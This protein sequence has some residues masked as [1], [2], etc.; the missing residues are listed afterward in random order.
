MKNQH[1][2]FTNTCPEGKPILTPRQFE[3]VRHFCEGLTGPEVAEAMGTTSKTV[4]NQKR[5]I[6][7]TLK[8]QGVRTTSC[9]VKWAIVTGV[10]E[11]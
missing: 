1:L 8:H 3:I 5:M 2:P 9:L 6:F 10:Y 7:A 11:L 4:D